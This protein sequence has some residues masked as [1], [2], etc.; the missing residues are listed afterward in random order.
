M[1]KVYSFA[2]YEKIEMTFRMGVLVVAMVG[3][4]AIPAAAGEI[5]G[6]VP[7]NATSQATYDR[8]LS[9]FPAAPVVNTSSQFVASGLDISGVGWRTSGNWGLTLVTPQHFVTAA[10]V[11]NYG[12]GEQVRFLGT[13]G[14]VRPYTVATD[15]NTGLVR[16]TRLTTT[17]TDPQTGTQQTRPSDILVV[18]LAAPIASSDHIA[19]LAVGFGTAAVG[20]DLLAYGQNSAYGSG[21]RHFG[22]NTLDEI[23]LNSFDNFASEATQ[24]AVYDYTRSRPGDIAL[25]SGD[26]G[27]PLLTRQGNTPVLLG[28]HY[29]VAG[30]LNDPNQPYFSAST[31]LPHYV[32]QLSTFVAA[33]G[34]S[35]T[36]VPV[37]EPASV[38]L[39]LAGVLAGVGAI[40]RHR[41]GFAPANGVGST[42]Q[43][44]PWPTRPQRPVAA[45]SP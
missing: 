3:S 37:P 28:T 19:P 7:G 21:T 43:K 17:Y 35:L 33:D 38:G 25:I 41:R 26:S 40:R 32:D 9:G 44:S 20:T 13:D 4:S 30:N 16:Q 34:Q 39:F 31:Y 15:P 45:I 6:Y 8:F 14:V 36:L 11:G 27:S 24:I 2:R 5:V 18:A 22:T 10:H 29:G 42:E 12:V 23:G 1:R